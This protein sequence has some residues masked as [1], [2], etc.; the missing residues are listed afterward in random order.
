MAVMALCDRSEPA[1]TNAGK[2][3]VA[4]GIDKK[5]SRRHPQLRRL[6]PTGP[7]STATTRPA[8]ARWHAADAESFVT[9]KSRSLTRAGGC[10]GR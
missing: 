8:T 2:A 5:L 4:P 3:S 9:K 1:V 6:T 7:P 10:G